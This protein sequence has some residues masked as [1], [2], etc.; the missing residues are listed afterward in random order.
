MLQGSQQENA[1]PDS[2]AAQRT[3]AAFQLLW[4]LTSVALSA[5]G[6]SGRPWSS[7]DAEADAISMGELLGR[8]CGWKTGAEGFSFMLGVYN[9]CGNKQRPTNNTGLRGDSSSKPTPT[10]QH[11]MHDAGRK[12]QSFAPHWPRRKSCWVLASEWRS[13]ARGTVE[14]CCA[15]V[16][17]GVCLLSGQG[18]LLPCIPAC[19]WPGDCVFIL[20]SLV[21]CW[22]AMQCQVRKPGS[23]AHAWEH[24]ET[25][26]LGRRG[27]PCCHSHAGRPLVSRGGTCI[28]K[29]IAKGG[30][31]S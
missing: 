24:L 5:H 31:R 25:A 19:I 9:A 6:S 27:R 7:P 16:W 28:S 10:S 20:W 29:L 18:R 8:P 21:G 1:G 13:G 11:S 30:S 15:G 22:T 26:A 12:M 3:I 4:W 23:S 17:A 2:H 14:A